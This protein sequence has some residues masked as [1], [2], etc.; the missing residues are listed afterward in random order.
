MVNK[1]VY[2]GQSSPVDVVTY[3]G[4]DDVHPDIIIAAPCSHEIELAEALL[5]HSRVTSVPAS[6]TTLLGVFVSNERAPADYTGRKIIS[7]QTESSID[8]LGY[9]R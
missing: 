9:S 2:K 4:P 5:E 1:D 6:T 8:N 3:C 7:R